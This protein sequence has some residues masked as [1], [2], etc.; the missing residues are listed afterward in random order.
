MQTICQRLARNHCG[1]KNN[2]ARSGNPGELFFNDDN[3]SGIEAQRILGGNRD[4]RRESRVWTT[5][6]LLNTNLL[7]RKFWN[8]LL[9]L[10]CNNLNIVYNSVK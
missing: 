8:F 5:D 6:K 1:T 10:Q 2:T 3:C 9:S 4:R 7:F